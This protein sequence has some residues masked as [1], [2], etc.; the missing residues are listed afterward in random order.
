METFLETEKSQKIPKEFVC[1]HCDYST[2]SKKD[3][4]KHLTTRKHSLSVDGNQ[5]ETKKIPKSQKSQNGFNCDHCGRSYNARSGLWKHN[6]LCVGFEKKQQPESIKPILESSPNLDK[7]MFMEIMKQNKELQNLLVEQNKEAQNVLKEQNNKLMEELKQSR[8]IQ[9]NTITNS[10]NNN[11]SNNSF[12]LNF[13]LNEQC[14]NAVNLM[15]FID[16][17]KVGIKDL[18]RTGRVGYVEGIS[19]IFLDGLRELDVYSR[20]IHCTDLKRETVYVKN[21]NKWE[22]ENEEK[23]RL[24]NAVKKIATKNLK[25]LS[26]WEKENPEFSNSDSKESEQYLVISKRSLGGFDEEE[27]EKYKDNILKNVLKQVVLEKK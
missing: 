22:K 5:M 23:S 11:N 27:D 2:S 7:D 24:K 9:N 8:Q 14:K 12:N 4:S 6:K 13:F 18:E 21:E 17:L 15:D 19:Q 10:N 3:Y 1:I 16:S 25:Q 20:P 26:N